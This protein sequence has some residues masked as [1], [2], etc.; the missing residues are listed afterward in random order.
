MGIKAKSMCSVRRH[1]KLIA[2]S[3]AVYQV[4]CTC[5]HTFIPVNVYYI[6]HSLIHEIQCKNHIRFQSKLRCSKRRTMTMLQPLI[7]SGGE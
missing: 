2:S 4:S 7:A 3:V 1:V 6:A 5:T